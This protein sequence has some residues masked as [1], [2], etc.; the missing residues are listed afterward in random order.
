MF[1][2]RKTAYIQRNFSSLHRSIPDPLTVR[3]DEITFELKVKCGLRAVTPFVVTTG[4]LKLS[5]SRFRIMQLYKLTK[6]GKEVGWGKFSTVNSSY[7]PLDMFSR[8]PERIR[9]S[10]ASL[11]ANP[12]NNI[13]ISV[14]NEHIYGWE[15]ENSQQMY[16]IISRTEFDGLMPTWNA[17]KEVSSSGSMQPCSVTDAL[18][19][20][21]TEE[22]VLKRVEDMQKLDL[23]DSEGAAVV[24]ARLVEIIG[25][26]EAA[27]LAFEERLLQPIHSCD[28]HSHS[29]DTNENMWIEYQLGLLLV[30]ESMSERDQ[31][32]NFS[33]AHQLI[34]TASANQS[35]H[36]L[37]LWMLSL[38]AKDASIIVTMRRVEVSRLDPSGQEV[39][40]TWVV[41]QNPERCG[42]VFALQHFNC[43]KQYTGFT[44]TIGLIDL[45]I[46]SLDKSWKKSGE[47]KKVC[48]AVQELLDAQTVYNIT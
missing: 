39:G 3:K 9:S 33:A 21:L 28:N 16:D 46:K 32:R 22:T 20:I 36:L 15:K 25:S 23:L 42:S 41:R 13:R 44:Y 43:T 24:F 47:D 12:Q 5:M 29:L 35:L 27:V 31:R 10:I 40:G 37:Q 14:N 6:F 19:A 4:R 48:K 7:D 11:M 18:A 1:T 17:S 38:I 34:S 26:I 30:S 45:G 2:L 8:V